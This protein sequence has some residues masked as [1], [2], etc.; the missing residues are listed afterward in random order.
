MQEMLAKAR[1]KLSS[2][3]MED[4]Y[5]AIELRGEVVGVAYCYKKV[6]VTYEDK[7]K[8]VFEMWD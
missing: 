8:Q 4:I 1:A 7:T 3:Q 5:N 6:V 2:L